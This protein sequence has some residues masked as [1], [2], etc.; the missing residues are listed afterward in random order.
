MT[1]SSII[2]WLVQK[3]QKQNFQH[4]GLASSPLSLKLSEAARG[5]G[6]HEKTRYGNQYDPPNHFYEKFKDP[7]LL[8]TEKTL[9]VKQ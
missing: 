9:Q 3:V 7:S 4:F 8:W 5:E 1:L 6:Q 2:G